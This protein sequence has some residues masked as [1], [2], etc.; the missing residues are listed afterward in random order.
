MNK[1]KVTKAINET[2]PNKKNR[3]LI[4]NIKHPPKKNI[5]AFID[6]KKVSVLN[7]NKR[8]VYNDKMTNSLS[9]IKLKEPGK[10][11]KDKNNVDEIEEKL[12]NYE[13]NNLDYQKAKKLDK[14][15]FSEIYWFLLNREHLILF[16]FCNR[17]DYNNIYIKLEGFIFLICTDMTLNVFFFA[18]ETMHKMFLDYGK[19]NFIQQ[20]PQ[21]IYSTIVSQFIQLLLSFLGLSDKYYYQ[22]KHMKIN[23]KKLENKAIKCI[24]IKSIFFFLY[25]FIMFI[26]YWY[27][28]TCFCGVY[29]NTQMA[30][31][32]DSISSFVLGLLYPFLLYLF[33]AVLRLISLRVK[34]CELSWL[35]A[36]SE[37]IPFF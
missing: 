27:R 36:I 8:N 17:N 25:T 2:M 16:T 35:F 12:D 29:V 28:I 15:K 13:L 30:F 18:D 6:K 21:I 4:K 34:K 11:F 7:K 10:D 22:I 19:Y 33:P 24:K 26:F 32:K 14:R 9:Q 23:E 1:I 20:I 37:I 31:I 5:F 3:I